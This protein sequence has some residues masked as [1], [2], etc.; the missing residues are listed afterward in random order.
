MRELEIT[1]GV[2]EYE[3]VVENWED[4]KK[5][6][7]YDDGT[8]YDI[9]LK[10]FCGEEIAEKL[11][12]SWALPTLLREEPT[13]SSRTLTAQLTEEEYRRLERKWKRERHIVVA[14]RIVHSLSL[15]EYAS[16]LLTARE[17]EMSLT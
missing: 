7:V 16:V 6:V 11:G 12:E 3:K 17:F 5:T 2:A 4:V 1:L 15:S 10:R 8:P 13:Q 9:T 14:N